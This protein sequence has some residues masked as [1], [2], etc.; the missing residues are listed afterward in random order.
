VNHQDYI[1]SQTLAKS[2]NLV[3]DLNS[4][5][6]EVEIDEGIKTRLKIARVI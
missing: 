2:I 3:D 1:G 4:S 6:K 5:G